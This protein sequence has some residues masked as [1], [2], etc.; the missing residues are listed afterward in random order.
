MSGGSSQPPTQTTQQ[1]LSPEQRELMQLA[2]PGL[3]DFAATVPE[4]YQGSA[5][6]GFDPNQ[7]AGQE[8]ALGAAGTIGNMAS[9]GAG[10]LTDWFSPGALDV[11]NNPNVRSSIDSATRPIYENLTQTALP[12]VRSSSAQTGNFGGSRQGI[13][14]GLAMQGAS[15]AAGDVSSRISS[16]AYNTNVKAQL[17]ALG[18]LPQT[19]QAQLAEATTTSGVGD[20]R[21]QQQQRLLDETVGNFNYD[22]YAPFLQSKEIMSLLSGLPGGSTVS[23]GSVPGQN[24][25]MSALGGAASGAALGSAIMPGIGTGVGAVGGALLPFLFN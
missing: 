21:Q 4:R 14:E 23:T 10:A 19:Q 9:S 12:A 8:Q 22:Q 24:K 25:A 6:A 15:N 3:R 13:A 5:V 11:Q 17:S 20:V 16:D 18:L 2:M 7:V 1:V